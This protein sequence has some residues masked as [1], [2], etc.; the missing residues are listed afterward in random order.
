[1]PPVY[2]KCGKLPGQPPLYATAGGRCARTSNAEIDTLMK[3]KEPL[4]DGLTE[5]MTSKVETTGIDE[6]KMTDAVDKLV[7]MA[8][9]P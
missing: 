1:M 2:R 5:L 3:R 7:A 4:E 8:G 6:A 9:N